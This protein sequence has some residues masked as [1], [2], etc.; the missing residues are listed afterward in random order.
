MTLEEKAG[1]LTIYGDEIRPRR[2]TDVNPNV[3]RHRAE[4]L[5]AEVREG[6]VGALFN[7]SGAVSGRAIQRIAVE[8][9]RLGIPLLF[10][11]DVLHG[12]RTVFPIPLAEAARF[13]PA[14]AE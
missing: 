14:L 11:A 8:D 12:F 5:L 6:R 7:G 9:S 13:A 1:Q 3:D 2:P 10:A 4:D